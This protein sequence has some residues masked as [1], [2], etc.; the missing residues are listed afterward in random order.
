VL[1]LNDEAAALGPNSEIQA[2]QK[3]DSRPAEVICFHEREGACERPEFDEV[4]PRAVDSVLKTT[5]VIL[6]REWSVLNVSV[7]TSRAV[8]DLDALR[9][10]PVTEACQLEDGYSELFAGAGPDI[11]DQEKRVVGLG[12]LLAASLNAARELNLGDGFWRED[13]SEWRIWETPEAAEW[14]PA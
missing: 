6:T 10:L 1:Q 11:L 13:N 7:A 12:M 8:T 5:T 9:G 2:C 4:I 14:R 3:G